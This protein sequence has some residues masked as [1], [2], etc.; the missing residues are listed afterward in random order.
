MTMLTRI[1]FDNYQTI[2]FLGRAPILPNMG[3][4]SSLVS[5]EHHSGGN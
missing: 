3:Q 5:K 2:D 1:T 4:I